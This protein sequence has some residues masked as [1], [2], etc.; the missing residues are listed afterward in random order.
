MSAPGSEPVGASLAGAQLS[1]PAWVRKGSAQVQREYA[2]GLEFERLLV[3]QLATSLTE[4]T[5]PSGEGEE[6]QA[7]GSG[8]SSS[9]LS[10]MLPGALAQGV[11]DGGGFGLAAEIAKGLQGTSGATPSAGTR[12]G[13]APAGGVEAD[14]TGGARA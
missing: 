7:G 8:G 1:E 6:G 14:V 3:Q 4:T 12:A 5:E 2:L 9:V 11:T 10:S 13:T